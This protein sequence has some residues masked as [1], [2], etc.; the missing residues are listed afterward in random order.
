MGTFESFFNKGIYRKSYKKKKKKKRK[1]NP[2]RD[3]MG[4]A[5]FVS[6]DQG[7]SLLMP[8]LISGVS[9]VAYLI[10]SD[11]QSR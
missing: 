10:P 6:P 2:P 11:P 5:W 9:A 4:I 3:V 7:M 8:T 1:H